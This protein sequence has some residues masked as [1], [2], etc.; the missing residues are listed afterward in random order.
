MTIAGD[1]VTYRIL[2]KFE[3]T[4]YIS[5]PSSSSAPPFRSFSLV[6]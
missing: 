5:F 4:G 1:G 6:K 3:D 2:P